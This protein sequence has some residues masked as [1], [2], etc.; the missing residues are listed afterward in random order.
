MSLGIASDAAIRPASLHSSSLVAPSEHTCCA[1]IFAGNDWLQVAQNFKNSMYHCQLA[2][3]QKIVLTDWGS[4]EIPFYSLPVLFKVAAI[5]ASHRTPAMVP[6]STNDH[7]IWNGT[8]Y[9]TG[10]PGAGMVKV[11]TCRRKHCAMAGSLD[12]RISPTPEIMSL[13]VASKASEA[14]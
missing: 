8:S 10:C 6:S 3:S 2:C 13:P 9:D 4:T 7:G 14:M 11:F 12:S 1:N 5:A